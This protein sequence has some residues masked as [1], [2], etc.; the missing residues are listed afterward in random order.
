MDNE[1]A[2]GWQLFKI[3]SISTNGTVEPVGD[4]QHYF[5]GK[6][7][8]YKDDAFT[9]CAHLCSGD[10]PGETLKVPLTFNAGMFVDDDGSVGLRLH[11]DDK[12][13]DRAMR[14]FNH[15]LYSDADSIIFGYK[16]SPDEMQALRN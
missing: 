13:W 2:P 9:D 6:L 8:Q 10:R 14:R 3:V 15:R 5:V 1:K 4:N 12:D 11:L 16:V 7:P